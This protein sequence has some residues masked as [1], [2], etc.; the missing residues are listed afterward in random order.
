M[1][2]C[3]HVVACVKE[4]QRE[5]ASE[6]ASERER[7]KEGASARESDTERKRERERERER[8]SERERARGGVEHKDGRLVFDQHLPSCEH[9]SRQQVGGVP[10]EQKM[11]KGHLLRVIY[12]QVF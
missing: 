5:R 6:R 4:R 12:H 10:R 9:S 1:W 11:L 8:D 7:G 3:L 2:V